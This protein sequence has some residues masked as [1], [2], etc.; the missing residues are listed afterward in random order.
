MVSPIIPLRPAISLGWSGWHWG[1]GLLDFYEKNK[2]S[3]IKGVGCK[4][5]SC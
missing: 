3:N 1:G 5:W 2:L 4:Y